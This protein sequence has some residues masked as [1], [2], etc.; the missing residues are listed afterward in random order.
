MILIVDPVELL[1]RITPELEARLAAS[2]VAGWTGELAFCLPDGRSAVLEID[3]DSMSAWDLA[4]KQ[5][6]INVDQATMLTLVLGLKAFEECAEVQ[7]EG[8][9]QT[10]REVCKALFPRQPTASGVWG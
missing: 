5:N 3:R 10:V 9:W 4:P 8:D 2:P 7:C 6:L 1:R